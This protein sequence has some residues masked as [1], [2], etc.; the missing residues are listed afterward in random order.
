MFYVGGAVLEDI[1]INESELAALLKVSR[2]TIQRWRVD[3]SGPPWMRAGTRP[4]RYKLS[5]VKI[6]EEKRTFRHRAAELSTSSKEP[7]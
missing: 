2:R 5:E 1:Y 3:G 6:W 4:V 7:P